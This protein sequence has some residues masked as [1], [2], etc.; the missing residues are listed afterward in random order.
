MNI[1]FIVILKCY[2]DFNFRYI[3][4]DFYEN[5]NSSYAAR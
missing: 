5:M 2:F 4:F 3:F 1:D